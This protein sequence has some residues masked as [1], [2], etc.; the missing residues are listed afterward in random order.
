MAPNTMS[1]VSCQ[2]TSYSCHYWARLNLSASK[3]WIW[4]QSGK[5]MVAIT[6]SISL[7]NS[8]PFWSKVGR[9]FWKGKWIHW[10][11]LL[12]AWG[13]WKYESQIN[14]HG[15]AW[16]WMDDVG[17]LFQNCMSKKIHANW[18]HTDVHPQTHTYTHIHVDVK[19]L[20]NSIMLGFLGMRIKQTY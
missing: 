6:T 15:I 12:V 10:R 4:L 13:P 5:M 18:S 1:K 20:S 9:C 19:D 8:L 7:M 16:C 17:H 2:Y 14:G 3:R 11:I